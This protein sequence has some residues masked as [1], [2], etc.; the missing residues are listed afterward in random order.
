[1]KSILK[2]GS[3][4]KKKNFIAALAQILRNLNET[5]QEIINGEENIV[6]ATF[7]RI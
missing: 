3:C 5:S 2:P 1:M 7:S 6:A 4:R